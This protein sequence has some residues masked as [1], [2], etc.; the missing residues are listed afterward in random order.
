MCAIIIK[1]KKKKFLFS[2]IFDNFDQWKKIC[3]KRI[4]VT[5]SSIGNA[6]DRER[7]YRDLF[8]ESRDNIKMARDDIYKL[9]VK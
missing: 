4:I 5:E 9:G 3:G 6:K 2:Q 1:L 8:D 7:V